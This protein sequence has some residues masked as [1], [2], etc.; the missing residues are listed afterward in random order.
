MNRRDSRCLTDNGAESSFAGLKVMHRTARDIPAD[1]VAIADLLTEIST[2]IENVRRVLEIT[3]KSSQT[4]DVVF[5]DD[6]AHCMECSWA[7]LEAAGIAL[8]PDVVAQCGRLL[9][10]SLDILHEVERSQAGRN[11]SAGT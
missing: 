3:A 9:Q 4:P 1:S 6:L 8:T 7:R 2:Q 10:A 11:D 5:V